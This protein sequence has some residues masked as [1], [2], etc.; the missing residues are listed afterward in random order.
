MHNRK[1]NDKVS[2]LPAKVLYGTQAQRTT[3]ISN[4]AKY[5]YNASNVSAIF[6]YFLL[7]SQN[8]VPQKMRDLLTF[9]HSF[10]ADQ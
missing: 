2:D 9:N 1:L 7:L 8:K 3:T 5:N 6:F 4:I 10:T